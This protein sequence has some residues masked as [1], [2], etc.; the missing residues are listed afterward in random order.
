MMAR[1]YNSIEAALKRKQEEEYERRARRGFRI[2]KL[3]RLE[4]AGGLDAEQ[5][6]E[7]AT[8]RADEREEFELM[9]IRNDAAREQLGFK[10]PDEPRPAPRPTLVKGASTEA[11]PAPADGPADEGPPN[12]SGSDEPGPQGA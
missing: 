2:L 7:L 11:P 8:L 9:K 10:E 6:R 12:P 4:E 3:Q 5:E 1:D